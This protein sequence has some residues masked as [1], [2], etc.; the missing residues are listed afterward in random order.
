[1]VEVQGRVFG[2]AWQARHPQNS[3]VVSGKIAGG[4]KPSSGFDK[5]DSGGVGSVLEDGQRGVQAH[6]V[7]GC[8]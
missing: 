7:S 4:E 6:C 2:V 1:M 5:R 3:G 8:R